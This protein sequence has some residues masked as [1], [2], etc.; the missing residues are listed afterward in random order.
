MSLTRTQRRLLTIY[1]KYR[2]R[3]M[4]I[5]S[6]LWASRKVYAILLGVF[7][8]VI[9]YFY[10]VDLAFI[11]SFFVVALA[12]TLLR[13]FGYFRRSVAIWPVLRE[14]IDWDRVAQ[15]LRDE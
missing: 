1:E 15:K 4:T 3:P 6:L 7:G 5:G 8:V 12:A 11:G 14:V 13:D 10:F 2:D 9:A